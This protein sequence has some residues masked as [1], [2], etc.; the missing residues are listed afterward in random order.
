MTN[1]NMPAD[2]CKNGE[3][4]D[5]ALDPKS[6]A[7][8]PGKQTCQNGMFGACIPDNTTGP[9]V[10]NG[11]DDD[12]DGKIDEE[13]GPECYPDGT[14]GC[15]ADLSGCQGQCAYGRRVCA[16]GKLGECMGAKTPQA[17]VCTQPGMTAAD[18][19]CDG[20]TD[21]K[22][23]CKNGETRACYNGLPADTAGKGRCKKGTQTCSGGV[24]GACV[25][26][27]D[28][29]AETCANQ[30]TDD[31][32]DGMQDNIP[33]L[34]AKC[35]VAGAMGPCA[36]GTLQCQTGSAELN[37]VGPAAGT[38]VCNEADDDCDG[39]IDDGFDL[40]KDPQ[41][42]GKCG[43]TCGSGEMCC[44]GNCVNTQTDDANCGVCGAPKC[45]AGTKCCSGTCKAV[46]DGGTCDMPMPCGNCGANEE[47]CNGTCVNTKTDVNNCSKCGQV[48]KS[49]TRP[50]CCAGSC[51]DL[52]SE[53]TCGRCDRTCGILDGG[54][55]CH[56]AMYDG[57]LECVGDL[58]TPLCL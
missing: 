27:V 57:G 31:N 41:N 7:C 34:G 8:G 18:E 39:M 38:E 54:T 47:C 14:S 17:E 6:G 46:A 15:N 49:G 32:C 53:S 43:K 56:C 26:E 58:L 44:A 42:C 1:P 4:R 33:N 50:G 11:N 16:N 3:Q 35:S 51:V 40:Q 5:C 30:G 55:L 45:G 29:Q 20:A 9:E 23:E 28:P 22:C 19:N 36:M 21:E 24:L 13:P 12:C 25:G 48:C 52:A 10:C 2:R 37:C